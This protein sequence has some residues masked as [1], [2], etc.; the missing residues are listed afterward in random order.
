M[1][2]LEITPYEPPASGWVARV[3]ML[4]RAIEARGGTCEVLDIGP[5]RKIARPGCVTVMSGGDYVRKLVGFARQRFAFHCHV[6]AEY[7]RGLLLALAAC[8]IARMLGNRVITTFHAG[9]KQ[10]FL[11][12]WRS[13]ALWPLFWAVFRL[14]HGVVCNSEEVRQVLRRYVGADRVFAIPAFSVQYM[15]FETVQLDPALNAF[16]EQRHP[17]FS[18]YLCFRDGFYVDVVVEA[19]SRFRERHRHFG[20]VLV[21]TGDGRADF[22]AQ[23]AA[24]SLTENVYLAGDLS[25]DRFMTL[26]S[27]S[28]L[29]LRTPTT[30]GVSSTVL[31]ALSL[32][33]PVVASEN[34]TRPLSVMTYKATDAGAMI[35]RIEAVL[36]D[37]AAA[38][39]AVVKPDI[40]D[41]VSEEV[42]LLLGIPARAPCESAARTEGAL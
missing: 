33:I 31:Q 24:R 18:T 19:L 14:S 37:H 12:G 20:L 13:V 25:H 27:R 30:D 10:P 8:L 42:D 39:A 29:H 5:N 28:A 32:G 1:R 17:L 9:A 21:G 40:R 26:L 4:R 7:F 16:I 6:N 35:N 11:R 22:E 41:T 36:R 3:K 23:L 34:G 2:V 38:V 15:Q